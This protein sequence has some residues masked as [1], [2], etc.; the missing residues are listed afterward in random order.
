MHRT[1]AL[2]VL[3]VFALSVQVPSGNQSLISTSEKEAI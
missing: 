2:G 1:L 3:L